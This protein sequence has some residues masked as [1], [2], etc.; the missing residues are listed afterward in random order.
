MCKLGTGCQ[1]VIFAV[2]S[3]P[4]PFQMVADE[5]VAQRYL[6]GKGLLA[7]L[8]LLSAFV[9]LSTDLYL[10]ALPRMGEYF[11]ASSALTNLTLVLFFIF[12]SLGMLFWGPFSDKYGRRPTLLVGLSVYVMAS[13]GCALSTDIYMLIA[14]RVLQAAGGSAASAVAT[15]MI[16]D[17][18][19][20]KRRESVLS[21]VQSMVLISPAVAPM[22]GASLLPLMSWRG[23]FWVLAL[24]GAISFIGCLLLQETLHV[25]FQG[26]MPQALRRLGAV[27]RNPG[28]SSLLL[29][30]SMVSLASLAF[31]AD[32]SYIY[33]DL[34]GLS[35]M[36]YSL[37]FGL[38]A[39]GMIAGPFLYLFLSRYYARRS[40]VVFSFGVMALAG[41]MVALFGNLGPLFFALAL[42]PAT[43]M[44]SAVRPA[45][46]FLMLEQQREDAGA[47]SSL[48]NCFGLVLGSLGMIIVSLAGSDLLLVL[49]LI[50]V[51]VGVACA[52]AWLAICKGKIALSM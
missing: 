52:T 47:A 34:F 51:F 14:C 22:L 1:N 2:T 48:I 42:L 44:G 27:L 16:K 25:R 15:A 17:V 40:I 31:I 29:V 30:F 23:L 5:V 41:L 8:A 18:Y 49:G 45:G 9:P 10:P 32:S 36:A 12:F 37:Y 50:N 4:H 43:L 20:G 33:Q 26:T 46:T 39:L 28:F 19:Q 13:M 38:N 21:I 7:L 6:G 24:I 35:P 11:G 3:R